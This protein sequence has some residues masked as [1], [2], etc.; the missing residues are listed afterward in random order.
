VLLIYGAIELLFK[1]G[2][3]IQGVTGII[4]A[5]LFML[6]DLLIIFKMEDNTFTKKILEFFKLK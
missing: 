5:S 6:S 2:K 4:V 3:I 1:N